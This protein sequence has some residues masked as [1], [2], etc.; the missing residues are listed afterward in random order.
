MSQDDLNMKVVSEPG[1]VEPRI[2]VYVCH[3]GGNISDVVDVEKVAEVISHLPNVVVSKHYMFMCSDPGQGMI[4]EDIKKENL[5]RV[6]VAA[7]SPSLHEITFRNAVSR[8]GLNPYLYENVNIREQVSWVS[9][10]DKEGAT[11]KA[12]KLVAAAVAKARLLEPLEPPKVKANEHVVVVGA[13]VSGMRT[14]RD[15]AR[16]GFSVTL[17]EESPFIGGRVAQLFKVFPTGERAKDLLGE[18]IEQVTNDSRIKI[19]TQAEIVDVSGFV[20]NYDVKVRLHPRGVKK[21]FDESTEKAIIDA[22]P[23]LTD[24]EFNY[25]LVKRKAIYRTYRGA[26]PDLLAVDWRVCTKCGKCVE[27]VGGEGIDLN[28][29]PQEIEITAGAIVLATGFDHYTPKVGEYGFGEFEEVVTLPQVIRMLDEDGPTGGEVLLN[30]KRVKNIVFIH[31]VGSRQVEGVNEPGPD[32]RIN[33]YCSRVCCTATLQTAIELKEK[34]P[35]MKIFELFQDIRTYGR[36][37]EDYYIDASRLGVAF[38][39]YEGTTPPVV[40]K[41]PEG[42]GSTLIVKVKDVLTFGEELEV[43]ADMVVLSTGMVPHDIDRLVDILKLPR[44]ADRFLQEVHPKL[45]PVELAITG[46]MIAGTCQAPMDITESSAASAAAAVKSSSLL[47]AGE[48]SLDPF[49]ARVDY[50]FCDGTGR[51]V[52]ECPYTGAIELVEMEIDGQRVKRARVNAAICTGCG[53][54]VAVC[55]TRAIQ[56]AGWSL[57]Q[58]DAMVDAIARDEL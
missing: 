28:E 8:A 53:A 22:C 15:L 10:S 21:S 32:G 9:K 12:I 3:C 40:E 50:K 49:V 34:Y 43:P 48:I 18:L 35:D 57:D 30:G 20:G 36:G 33:N 4:E 5:N 55:P 46:V 56:I 1:K 37:H 16:K 24:N 17:L 45:R 29:E 27:V 26:Y 2:G 13:G 14:A 42:S 6:I 38:F 41:A 51:C 25:N 23:E 44:S 52:E 54:C 11:G 19:Y 39:R 47:G 7:C 58:F 31:C